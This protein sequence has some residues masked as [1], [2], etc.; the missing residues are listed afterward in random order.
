V[1]S[2]ASV[3][4]CSNQ[5]WCAGYWYW[6][7]ATVVFKSFCPSFFC[8]RKRSRLRLAVQRSMLEDRKMRTAMLITQGN[9]NS[10]VPIF[11]S[12]IFLSLFLFWSASLSLFTHPTRTAVG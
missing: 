12:S 1:G 3:F 6:A 9:Q 10:F 5:R 7:L 11:L 8:H 2:V 4:S